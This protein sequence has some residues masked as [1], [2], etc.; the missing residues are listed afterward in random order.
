MQKKTAYSDARAEVFFKR[1]ARIFD[2]TYLLDLSLLPFGVNEQIVLNPFYFTQSKATI[3]P[4]SIPEIER[5]AAILKENPSM[6]IRI[7]GHTDNLGKV[8]DL[9]KLSEDRASAIK[10]ALIAKGILA[11]RMEVKGFGGTRPVSNNE[12]DDDRKKNRRVE[13]IITKI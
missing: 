4:I 9:Q 5:L 7:E 10:E 13:V 8:T 6:S 1:E 2:G 11:A 12:S 3:L